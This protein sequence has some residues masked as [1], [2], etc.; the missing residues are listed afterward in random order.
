MEYHVYI[1]YSQSRNIFYT[2]ITSDLH[3]RIYYHNNA[4]DGFTSLGRPWKVLWSTSKPAKAD[5][6]ILEK[7]IKNLSRVRKIQFI[8]KYHNEILD[9]KLWISIID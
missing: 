6:L 1:I 8:E 9:P 4:L 7:K 2:G 5:A 3:K